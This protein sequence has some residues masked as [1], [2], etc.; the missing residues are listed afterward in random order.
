MWG[1]DVAMVHAY[2]LYKS[3]MEMYKMAPK[4]HYRFRESVAEA[5]MDSQNLWTDRYPKRSRLASVS[6][7]GKSKDHQGGSI[8]SLSRQTRSTVM[9]APKKVADN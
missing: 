5:W 4:S 8:S 9:S 2:T 6:L 1:L 3:W 7:S